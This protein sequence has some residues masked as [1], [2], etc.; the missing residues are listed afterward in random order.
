VLGKADFFNGSDNSSDIPDV[1]FER[2][3]K[4][5]DKK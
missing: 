5:S 2:E 1:V 4:E 3:D